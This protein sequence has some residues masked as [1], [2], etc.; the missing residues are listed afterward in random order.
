MYYTKYRQRMKM[1]IFIFRI[2]SLTAKPENTPIN[3]ESVYIQ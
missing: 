1:K 2:N 3:A